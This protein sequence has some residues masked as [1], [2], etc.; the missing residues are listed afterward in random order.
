[1]PPALVAAAAPP[2][3]APLR[4]PRRLGIDV[5]EQLTVISFD[6]PMIAQWT[7][8]QLPA[9]RQPLFSMAQV[10]IE[11]L[12]ALSSDPGLFAPPFKLETQLIERESTAPA[13]S[14]RPER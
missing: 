5:P 6:D 3:A 2:A 7:H 14:T 10:A 12:L 8:P 9:E 4:A 13:R 1:P 11:R